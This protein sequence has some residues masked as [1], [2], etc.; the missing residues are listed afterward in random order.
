MAQPRQPM[1]RPV[2]IRPSAGSAGLALVPNQLRHSLL[3]PVAQ[4]PP[5]P[6][7]AYTPEQLRNRMREAI[8]TFPAEAEGATHDP[9]LTEDEATAQ[10][11]E[12]WLA[13]EEDD[14]FWMAGDEES[15]EKG[16][17][18]EEVSW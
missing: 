11:M 2:L 7:S 1:Q 16:V 17:E 13:G 9:Y 3:R 10:Q 12:D 8:E 14:E 4:P 15:E 18:P 6:P 5:P